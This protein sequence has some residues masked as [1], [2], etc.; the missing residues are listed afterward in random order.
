MKTPM[1][2]VPFALVVTVSASLGQNLDPTTFFQPPLRVQHAHIALG[3]DLL[4]NDLV[5]DDA[6]Y[7]NAGK[8]VTWTLGAT[9]YSGVGLSV[10]AGVH[11]NAFTQT[12]GNS[13]V[14]GRE[15]DIVG[16]IAPLQLDQTLASVTGAN[17]PVSWSATAD[18]TG[19]NIQANQ[20]YQVTFD[21]SAGPSIPVELL[22]DMEFNVTS[23]NVT[24]FGGGADGLLNLANVI[25]I[26]NG[27]RNGQASLLFSSSTSRSD[28]QFQFDASTL[29]GLGLLGDVEGNQNVL[30]F[31]NIQVQAVPEPSVLA[32]SALAAG[33]VVLRR[34][35]GK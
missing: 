32:F 12:T 30:T 28:L 1:S 9:G 6:T 17:L 2:L 10:I 23:Q 4:N 33:G 27:V 21:I 29:V 13:L 3:V 7:S 22:G 11:L 5:E 16:V 31:S 8:N 25:S 20:L 18:L 35:R 24:S 14:F 26:G 15:L 34:R 19:L